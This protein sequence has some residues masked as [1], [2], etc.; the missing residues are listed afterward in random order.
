MAKYLLIALGIVSVTNLALFL[1]VY[2][3]KANKLADA[4]YAIIFVSIAVY[5]LLAEGVEWGKATLFGMLA[6]WACRVGLFSWLRN[7][8]T[9]CDVR[10]NN[11]RGRFWAF[12]GFVAL[13]S[14][15]VWVMLFPALIAFRLPELSCDA[16]SCAGFFLLLTGFMIAT[17]A[18][19]QRYRYSASSLDRDGWVETGLWKYSRHPNYFGEML[20]WLGLYLFIVSS[21]TVGEG[22]LAAVGAVVSLF[23]VLFLNGVRPIERLADE[24]WG[25]NGAYRAYKARTSLLVILPPKG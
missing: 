6:L 11:L 25:K 1:L 22:L 18:D 8:R 16:L 12:T 4:S 23:M 21:L 13:Q 14:L 5:G 20:M 24:R 7:W 15:A 2:R 19:W 9:G 10:L 3:L 17:I